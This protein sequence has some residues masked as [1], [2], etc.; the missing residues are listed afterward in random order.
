[1]EMLSETKNV[2]LNVA[3]LVKAAAKLQE[4]RI[5]SQQDIDLDIRD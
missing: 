2:L 3:H 5:R 1:M 4:V